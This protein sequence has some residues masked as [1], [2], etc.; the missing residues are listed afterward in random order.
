MCV[1]SCFAAVVEVTVDIVRVIDLV[2]EYLRWYLEIHCIPETKRYAHEKGQFY[3]DGTFIIR[4][5]VF[6]FSQR[7]EPTTFRSI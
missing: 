6:N 1:I 5:V 3:E 2:C 4:E 7:E